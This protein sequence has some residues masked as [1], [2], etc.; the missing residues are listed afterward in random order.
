MY[1]RAG[2]VPNCAVLVTT[3][4][5]LKMHGGGPTVTSGQ[6]LDPAYSQV[7]TISGISNV[8][9]VVC[10]IRSTGSHNIGYDFGVSTTTFAVEVGITTNF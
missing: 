7:S 5:S 8:L 4:R 2:L 6:P 10:M 1:P 3:V 9:L